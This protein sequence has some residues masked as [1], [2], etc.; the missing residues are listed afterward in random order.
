MDPTI[1]SASPVDIP[2]ISAIWW[3]SMLF[4]GDRDRT[5]APAPGGRALFEHFLAEQLA[6]AT[7]NQ[8]AVMVAEVGGA[9]AAYGV[10]V[11]RQRSGYFALTEY[12]LITDLDV[13]SVHRR[14][15]LGERVLQ[16]LV[17][18]L[19]AREVERVEVEVVSANETSAAFWRKQGFRTF[20]EAMRRATDEP[21]S[22]AVASPTSGGETTGLGRS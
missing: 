8:A 13:A 21:S 11:L 15:G 9:V 18:W 14:R 4:H 7:A 12:G 19:R 3:E 20:Y 5:F 16:A 10:A 1:R 22:S 2:A 6:A 17:G